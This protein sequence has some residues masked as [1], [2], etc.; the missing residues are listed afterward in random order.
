M[1]KAIGAE[2]HENETKQHASNDD[3]V[4]HNWL[5]I[6]VLAVEEEELLGALGAISWYY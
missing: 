2:N 5:V 4:F 3:D 1:E 6:S